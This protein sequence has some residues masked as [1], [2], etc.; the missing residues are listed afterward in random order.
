MRRSRAQVACAGRVR[1]S[2]ALV[3]G[4]SFC[5]FSRQPA[6][7]ATRRAAMGTPAAGALSERKGS[8]PVQAGRWIAV[9]ARGP[10]TV[11]WPAMAEHAFAYTAPIWKGEK[12]S[13]EPV[14]G[15]GGG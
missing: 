6:R 8:V 10:R 14:A 7:R 12:G 3:W 1:W 15:W 13:T 2:R 11:T 9:R 4:A 5:A